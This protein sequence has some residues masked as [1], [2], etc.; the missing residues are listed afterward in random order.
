M[1]A[2]DKEAVGWSG[3]IPEHLLCAVLVPFFRY[4]FDE[5]N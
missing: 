2:R 3:R 5:A 1:E 4:H